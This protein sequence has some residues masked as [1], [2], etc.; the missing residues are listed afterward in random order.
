[1]ARL[2]QVKLPSE[3]TMCINVEYY[4]AI[5]ER[6]QHMDGIITKLLRSS[7]GCA[8]VEKVTDEVYIKT[9]SGKTRGK[10]TKLKFHKDR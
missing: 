8:F 6:D 3:A 10:R 2:K 9:D 7:M 1:M 5:P 4:P